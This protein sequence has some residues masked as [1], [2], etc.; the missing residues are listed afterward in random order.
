MHN[1]RLMYPL[2]CGG[3]GP[4]RPLWK[5]AKSGCLWIQGQPLLP[6][7]DLL[8]DFEKTRIDRYINSC[9]GLSGM[10]EKCS[11]VVIPKNDKL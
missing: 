3:D 7:K 8:R 5:E 11:L 6:R 2:R 10:E 9:V 1:L 4:N